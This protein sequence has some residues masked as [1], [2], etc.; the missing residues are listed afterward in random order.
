M[1][2]VLSAGLATNASACACCT[3]DGQRIEATGALDNYER[4]ELALVRFASTAKLY[5]DPG[6]PDTIGGIVDPSTEDY[7]LVF[8]GDEKQLAFSFRDAKGRKGSVA[9]PLPR[10]FTRFEVDPRESG[11][12]ENPNGPT[13]YKEWRLNGVA[14]L[15]G[16]LAAKGRWARADLI[17]HGRGNS[18]TSASDFDSWTLIV[19][20]KGIRF[21]FLGATVQ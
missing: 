5:A 3:D 11:G 6:Y 21:T 19:K 20:G 9:F 4:G 2:A 18:C 7:G 8:S 12:I 17:L 13:L 14:K 15:D 16:V 1:V 10:R